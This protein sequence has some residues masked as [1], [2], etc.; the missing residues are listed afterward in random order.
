VPC[1]H[2]RS[3][4][5]RER[6]RKP[7]DNAEIVKLTK[8]EMGDEVIVAKIKSATSVQFATTTDD[9]LKLKQAGVSKAVIAAMLD[10]STPPATTPPSSHGRMR[11]CPPP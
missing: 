4:S 7:L 5:G 6:A 8:A 1:S 2:L 3:S 9:L 10:K 11:P